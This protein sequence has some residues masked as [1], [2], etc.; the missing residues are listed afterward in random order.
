MSKIKRMRKIKSRRRRRK[1]KMIPNLIS[2]RPGETL[3]GSEFFMGFGGKGANQ[4]VM[5]ARLGAK[6]TIVA[7]VLLLLLSLRLLLLLLLSLRL[8]LLSL[9]T[10]SAQ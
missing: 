4:C 10:G 8:L 5:A 7:K 9:H 1:E 6:T 3:L 2:P